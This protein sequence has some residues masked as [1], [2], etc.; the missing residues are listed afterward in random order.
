MGTVI[1]LLFVRILLSSVFVIVSWHF[2]VPSV[3][4]YCGLFFHLFVFC[5]V[6]YFILY[7]QFNSVI[8]VSRE[9]YASIVFKTQMFTKRQ[10]HWMC[11]LLFQTQ[12]TFSIETRR[13]VFALMDL[14]TLVVF[15]LCRFYCVFYVVTMSVGLHLNDNIENGTHQKYNFVTLWEN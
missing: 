7:F 4:T 11:F 14:R 8:S 5:V 9:M 10:T 12:R 13:W 3:N 6:T 15:Q 2:G 1:L